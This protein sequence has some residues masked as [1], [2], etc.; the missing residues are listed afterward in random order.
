MDKSMSKDTEDSMQKRVRMVYNMYV[1]AL[2]CGKL[3]PCILGVTHTY[4][5]LKWRD[6]KLKDTFWST[7]AIFYAGSLIA[8]IAEN[9]VIYSFVNMQWF[10]PETKCIIKAHLED[11]LKELNMHTQPHL[12][13]PIQ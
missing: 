4:K 10:S 9:G 3:V 8:I 2:R 11:L 6:Y 1:Q 7:T 5:S 12:I 13:Y